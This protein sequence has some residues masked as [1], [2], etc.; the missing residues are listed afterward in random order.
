MLGP[1]YTGRTPGGYYG[2]LSPRAEGAVASDQARLADLL[3]ARDNPPEQANPETSVSFM[4]QFVA[5]LMETLGLGEGAGEE[6]PLYIGDPTLDFALGT[7]PDDEPQRWSM[8]AFGEGGHANSARDQRE[9]PRDLRAQLYNAGFAPEE[10][11]QALDLI[12]GRYDPA[13]MPDMHPAYIGIPMIRNLYAANAGG[14]IQRNMLQDYD[15]GSFPA[16][17]WRNYERQGF[18]VPGT[19]FRDAMID[20]RE[21][22]QRDFGGP[23]SGAPPTK[24]GDVPQYGGNKPPTLL[25]RTNPRGIG[26]SYAG[27]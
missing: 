15:T 24:T 16:E 22:S 5:N 4:D 8:D 23:G 27:Y 12:Y 1:Q 17:V 13:N 19:T 11:S 10:L 21:V 9:L 3:W 14:T 26:K 6:E 2:D 7:D 20:K 25:S 18:Q